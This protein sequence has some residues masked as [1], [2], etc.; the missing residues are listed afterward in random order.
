MAIWPENKL[1]NLESQSR[2][3]LNMIAWC[4]FWQVTLFPQDFFV[5]I[6]LLHVKFFVGGVLD[7]CRLLACFLFLPIYIIKSQKNESK[8]KTWQWHPHV[9]SDDGTEPYYVNGST[10]L[11]S[12]VRYACD[13]SHSLLGSEERNCLGSPSINDVTIFSQHFDPSFLR[14]TTF[15]KL[16]CSKEARKFNLI[17]HLD[18]TFSKAVTK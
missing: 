4:K 17:L 2:F 7:A 15:L 8:K 6:L 11:D 13:R 18:L 14:A 3:W 1:F 16:R 5:Y 12:I 9:F 10:H